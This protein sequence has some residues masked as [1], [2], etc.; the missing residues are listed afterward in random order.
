MDVSWQAWLWRRAHA[1]AWRPPNRDT[2]L[3]RLRRAER[4]GLDYR[5]YAGVLLDR[6]A[7][8]GGA[9]FAFES[10][11]RRQA[12]II[13]ARLAGLR[14]C[15]I[16]LCAADGARQALSRLAGR[17]VV[18]QV[19]QGFVGAI[20]RFMLA[21]RLTP[22]GTFMVGTSSAHLRAAEDCALALFLWADDY[23]ALPRP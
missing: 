16:L 13:G 6:G 2:A 3:L 4:L 10:I 11:D 1:E 9:I 21:N 15:S 7:H 17:T 19:G 22:G 23:F 20:D 14:D 5:T 12:P 8:L 18:D